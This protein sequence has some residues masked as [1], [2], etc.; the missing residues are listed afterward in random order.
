MRNVI[1]S[2]ADGFVGSYTV[3]KFLEEGL[4]VLALGVSE[5]ACRLESNNNMIYIHCIKGVS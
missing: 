3:A 2:G 1:I 4:Q 5:N